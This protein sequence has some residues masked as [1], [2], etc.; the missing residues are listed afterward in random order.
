MQKLDSE[1][2]VSYPLTISK[3][4]ELINEGGLGGTRADTSARGPLL[5]SHPVHHS[6]RG[7]P[8]AACLTKE[9]LLVFGCPCWHLRTWISVPDNGGLLVLHCADNVILWEQLLSFWES[10][11]LV[12]VGREVLIWPTPN[13]H[14]GHWVSEELPWSITFHTWSRLLKE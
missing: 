5:P 2:C 13:K 10:E 8:V 6:S 12:P 4:G 14:P 3:C 1:T 11:I 7:G 9:G